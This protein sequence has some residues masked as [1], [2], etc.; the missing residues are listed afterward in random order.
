MPL[1]PIEVIR[2]LLEGIDAQTS[3]AALTGSERCRFE[4]VARVLRRG[5]NA[6]ALCVFVAAIQK[7]GELIV[8]TMGLYEAYKRSAQQRTRGEALQRSRRCSK[9]GSWIGAPRSRSV[10]PV[11][12]WVW[13]FRCPTA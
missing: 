3:S 9:A 13:G 2:G 4:G 5:D 10:P 7:S 11:R 1:R 12:A 6:A 8:L